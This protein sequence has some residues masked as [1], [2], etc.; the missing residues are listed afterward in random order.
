MV[1]EYIPTEADHQRTRAVVRRSMQLNKLANENREAA[2][3]A[4][5]VLEA[6]V[7]KGNDTTSVRAGRVMAWA[8]GRG[9]IDIEDIVKL[10]ELERNAAGVLLRHVSDFGVA[11][12]FEEPQEEASYGM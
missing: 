12:V 3:A 8:R 10:N 11:P 2:L 7:D 5:A 9:E 1:E 6:E 4:F